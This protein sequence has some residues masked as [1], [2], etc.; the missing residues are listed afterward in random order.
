MIYNK[1]NFG[2]VVQS[3]DSETGD[4]VSLQF[5]SDGRIERQNEGGETISEE[6]S[7]ELSNVEKDCSFDMVQP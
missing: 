5:V 2:Y 6:A 4:C 7:V 1:L 3:I